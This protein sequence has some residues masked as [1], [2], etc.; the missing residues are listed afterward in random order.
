MRAVKF[1]FFSLMCL[2]AV[3]G[4]AQDY[5]DLGLPSGTKWKSTN[6]KGFYS[7]GDAI[8]TFGSSLPSQEQWM[9][10]RNECDWTWSRKGYKVVGP[11]GNYI[12]LPAAGYRDCNGDVDYVGSYGYYWSSTPYDSDY[13]WGLYFRSGDHGMDNGHR[14]YGRSVRLVAPRP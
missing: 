11:N 6:E 4:Q 12:V 2:M 14:C 1:L 10:L 7:Y 8:G 13:A 5:V 9:E 3:T